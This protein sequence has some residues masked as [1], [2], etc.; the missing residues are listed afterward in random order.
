[1]K[2]SDDLFGAKIDLGLLRVEPNKIIRSASTRLKT[3][4]LH[5]IIKGHIMKAKPA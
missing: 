2:T 1:M 4:L 3:A 5:R